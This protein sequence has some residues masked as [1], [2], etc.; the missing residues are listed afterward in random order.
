MNGR[1]LTRR[2]SLAA[3]GLAAAAW[4]LPGCASDG[5]AAARPGST[6]DRTLADKAG[7]GVLQA[8]PGVPLL[9][10][11]ELA[12]LAGRGEVV[13][14]IAQLS[15]LHVGD[16]QSPARVPFLDRLGPR[17]G[18]AFR[19]HETLAPL[20]LAGVLDQVNAAR[21]DAVLL[22]GDL[23][24]SAQENELDWV[25][26]LLAGRA[27]RPDSGRRGY[28][29][30]QDA[31]N[32]DPAYYRPAVDAPRRSGLLEQALAPLR[33]SGLRAPW[34]PV[35]G[36][37]DVLVQG[38]I[39]P[40]EATRAVARGRRLVV[41]PDGEL[42]A[43][44]RGGRLDRARIDALLRE[45]LP[46]RAIQVPSDQS[47]G[48][49][50]APG[51]V[52][53][54]R[55]AGSPEHSAGPRAERLDY[56]FTVGE[57]LVVIALDIARRD[58]GGGGL[59]TADATRFL[60]DALDAA[61]E[62]WVIVCVHQPLEGSQDSAQAFALLDAD[63][64]VVAVLSGHTHRNAI[65]PRKTAAGGYWLIT[66]ASL[67]DW[68]QQWRMLRLR[69]NAGGPLIETWMVDQPGRPGDT[70]DAAGVARDLAYI[71][72]Q[73]GRP[74]GADGPRGARN[75]RLFL[76]ARQPRAPRPRLRG[77]APPA[78]TPPRPLSPLLGDTL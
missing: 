63:P 60:A 65:T 23:I 21:P 7:A 67:I 51:V 29:G 19:P 62:R 33:T 30:V 15:D 10:R 78:G 69:E 68:P 4:V 54:L 77:P 39:G 36:N 9:E 76:A 18:S 48:H 74:A 40:S 31:G 34:Y 49:L 35:L 24:D 26:G 37:H 38:A 3:A 28:A 43:L 46:G 56:S 64:R 47:R 50:D 2:E 1:G 71:D 52:R 55:A 5:P 17:L 59:V 73:G 72:V 13:A 11:T 22:S 41:S 20:I 6:L 75:A 25:L 61:G 32:P 42:L 53:R 16:A 8:G 66:T 44:A 70:R 58:E 12:A 45:G 14:T 57:R 27:V